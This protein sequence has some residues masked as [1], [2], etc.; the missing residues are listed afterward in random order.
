VAGCGGGGGG[1]AQA[2][3]NGQSDRSSSASAISSSPGT[4]PINVS[5]DE[6]RISASTPTAKAGEVV[7]RVKNNGSVTHEMVVLRTQTHA[8]DLPGGVAREESSIGEVADIAPHD[9]KSLSLRLQPGHYVLICNEPGHY[10]AGMYTDFTI[11]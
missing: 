11:S 10:M 4:S 9:A 6:W 1:H 7:F 5:L 2:A 3:T 8:G